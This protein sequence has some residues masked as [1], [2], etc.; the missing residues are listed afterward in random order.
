M[1]NIESISQVAGK[2]QIT[3]KLFELTGRI[4]AMFRRISDE[5]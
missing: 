3:K 4:P 1:R 5:S 2:T